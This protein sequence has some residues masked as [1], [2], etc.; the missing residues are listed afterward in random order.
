VVALR[1]HKLEVKRVPRVTASH[2]MGDTDSVTPH[3]I[4]PDSVI[5]KLIVLVTV[6]FSLLDST[7]IS[8]VKC[9]SKLFNLYRNHRLMVSDR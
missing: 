3:S 7:Q 6:L 1:H 2:H 9:L 4:S 5:N 8:T